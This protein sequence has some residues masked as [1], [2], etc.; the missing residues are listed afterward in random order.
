MV[1][2]WRMQE[3]KDNPEK[4][5]NHVEFLHRMETHFSLLPQGRRCVR[6]IPLWADI[7]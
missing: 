3:D 1:C 6:Y 4:D 7:L 2:T 5:D